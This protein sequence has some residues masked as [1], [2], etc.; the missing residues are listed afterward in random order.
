MPGTTFRPIASAPAASA[1]RTPAASVTPQILTNG[2]RSSAARSSGSRPAAANAGGCRGRIGRA[3]QGLADERRVEAQRPP[4]GDRGR[5]ADARF[6]DDEAIVRHELAQAHRPLGVDR[7]RPQVAVVEADQAGT[8]RERPLELPLVVRLDERLQPK[9]QGGS[10]QAP[11]ARRRVEA[12]QQQDEVRPGRPQQ[13]Q[14]A[15]IDDELLGQDRDADGRPHRAQV[16][17]R[18]AEPVRLAQDRDR[19]PR[20]RAA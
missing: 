7:Q 1:A 10:D 6:G 13:G 5:V 19:P 3:H 14:L 8:G 18:A 17:D 15:R 4:A 12:G 16:V 2:A 20:H 9:V 11:E